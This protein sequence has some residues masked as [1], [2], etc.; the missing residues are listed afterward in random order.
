MKDETE[1]NNHFYFILCF[2]KIILMKQRMKNE[3]EYE[4]VA[5]VVLL[6]EKERENE[7]RREN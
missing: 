4:R 1:E 3:G 6:L 5:G 7:W 2:E